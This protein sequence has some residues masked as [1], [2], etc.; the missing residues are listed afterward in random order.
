MTIKTE[1]LVAGLQPTVARE[2]NAAGV[3][4]M[5]DH[6]S[7]GGGINWKHRSYFRCNEKHLWAVKASSYLFKQHHNVVKSSINCRCTGM[8]RFDSQCSRQA[9]PLPDLLHACCKSLEDWSELYKHFPHG[10]R[11]RCT[12]QATTALLPCAATLQHFCGPLQTRVG[13]SKCIERNTSNMVAPPCTTENLSWV[14]FC[15]THICTVC[16]PYFVT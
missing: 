3:Q 9:R 5:G 6:R 10:E 8:H 12:L 11:D 4:S 15:N 13:L 14:R 16:S 2:G 7:A 1:K